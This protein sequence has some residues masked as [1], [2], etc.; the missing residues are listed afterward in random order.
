MS[1]QTVENIQRL[2]PFLE[3]LQKRLLQTGFGTFD[4]ET[5]T[6]PGLLDSRLNLPGFQIAGMDPLRS[7]AVSL[8]E[9]LVGS[10]RPFIQGA[11]DQALAGQQ[12]LTQGMQFLQPEAIERFQNPF[13][14][15]VIDATMDQLNRQ[16]DLRRAGASAA[17]VRSGAFGGSREGIQR[18]E[19]ERGL[20]QVKGDTLSRLLSSGFQSAL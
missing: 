14:Q 4:G 18:A 11:A 2:P 13:Q 9:N 17:A 3:G 10:F 7:R 16:A 15:Q 5:Q 6:T 1:T 12:A 8:G 19:T 20:Q